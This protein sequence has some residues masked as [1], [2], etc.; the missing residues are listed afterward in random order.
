[1]KRDMD[2]VRAIFLIAENHEDEYLQS[3]DF[4]RGLSEQFPDLQWSNEKL[5]VH[6]RLLREARLVEA[7][8]SSSFG[9]EDFYDL[10]L[11][12]EGH[13][14]IADASDPR[15]WEEAKSKGGEA[16]FAVFKQILVEVA[17]KMLMGK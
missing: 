7:G 16:S 15:V 2:L 13:E 8:F 4:R 1:M 10:R 3:S 5:V 17:K 14:F 9:G 12:W 6:V 11:T